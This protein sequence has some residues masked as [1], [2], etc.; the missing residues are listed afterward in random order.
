M[1]MAI[2]VQLKEDKEKRLHSHYSVAQLAVNIANLLRS[3]DVEGVQVVRYVD[4]EDEPGEEERGFPGYIYNKDPEWDDPVLAALGR[5]AFSYEKFQE[6][7]EAAVPTF[8][9]RIIRK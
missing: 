8:R 1:I 2:F 4:S 3:E 6:T 9:L 7:G 5:L